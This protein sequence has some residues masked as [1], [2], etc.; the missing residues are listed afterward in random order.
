ME[1]VG[2]MER[3]AASRS[4]RAMGEKGF[5]ACVCVFIVSAGDKSGAT[6]VECETSSQVVDEDA[7][8]EINCCFVA[9]SFK[10]VNNS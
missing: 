1:R 6:K 10:L 9:L 5:R 7:E 8:T 2:W 4:S 3:E